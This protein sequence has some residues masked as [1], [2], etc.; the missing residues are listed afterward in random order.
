MEKYERIPGYTWFISVAR[1]NGMLVHRRVY[2]QRW[3]L[4]FSRLINSN[5][6][7]RNKLIIS[8]SLF[9]CFFITVTFIKRQLCTFLRT[10]IATNL[11]VIPLEQNFHEHVG[12]HISPYCQ[13]ASGVLKTKTPKTPKTPEDP[14]RPQNLKAKTPIFFGAPKLRPVGRQYE[15]K[16]SIGDK[17]FSVLNSHSRNWFRFK[18]KNFVFCFKQGTYPLSLRS[19]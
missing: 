6:F 16:L 2:T 13:T 19:F 7:R 9:F 8:R 18:S 11:I 10:V 14:Q 17:N 5:T 15:C 12:R 1:V 4:H 3:I